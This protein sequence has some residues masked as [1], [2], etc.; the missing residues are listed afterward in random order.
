[1]A[2]KPKINKFKKFLDEHR[3]KVIIYN[4]IIWFLL[5][6][7]V[8]SYN[9]ETSSYVSREEIRQ[10]VDDKCSNDVVLPE[11]DAFNVIFNYNSFI[12]TTTCEVV[13]E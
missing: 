12:N 5:L 7:I 3:D 10:Q 4:V 13:L 6:V 11:H 1:M 9:V 8:I 2:K